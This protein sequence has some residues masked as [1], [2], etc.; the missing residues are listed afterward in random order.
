MDV[1]PQRLAYIRQA[2]DRIV[3]EGGYPA[4]V[5]ATDSRAEALQGADA[6]ICTILAGGVDVW[7]YDI[8]I[9]KSFGVDINVGDTRGPPA[10][11]VPCALSR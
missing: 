8:E 5:V 6:V 11:F 7:R 4:Q 3:A 2:V 9:P 10:S 1:D